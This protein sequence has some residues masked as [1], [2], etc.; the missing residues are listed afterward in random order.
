MSLDVLFERSCSIHSSPVVAEL[1]DQVNQ[2][3]SGSN[4]LA[5]YLPPSPFVAMI[6]HSPI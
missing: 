3:D 1:P 5:V 4:T 6:C 2:Q